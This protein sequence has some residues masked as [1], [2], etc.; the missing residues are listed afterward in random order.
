M[1]NFIQIKN[2]RVDA[3]LNELPY[4]INLNDYIEL[5][6]P[7]FYLNHNH[8]LYIL[9][10][11]HEEAQ[12]LK[13]EIQRYK[14]SNGGIFSYLDDSNELKQGTIEDLA[15]DRHIKEWQKEREEL[16]VN[17]DIKLTTPVRVKRTDLENKN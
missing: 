4:N 10:D 3:T 15:A 1:S 16:L 9:L 13:S 12:Y 11:S 5:K 6:N 7:K 2:I 17:G 14:S 8:S